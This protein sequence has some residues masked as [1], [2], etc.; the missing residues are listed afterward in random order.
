MILMK[1]AKRS[2]QSISHLAATYLAL[3][4][5]VATSINA[6][7]VLIAFGFFTIRM[8]LGRSLHSSVNL[9]LQAA[10]F[11]KHEAKSIQPYYYP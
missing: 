3:V 10:R 5:Y 9:P 11:G 1:P 7:S 4:S 8:F 2:N 6:F